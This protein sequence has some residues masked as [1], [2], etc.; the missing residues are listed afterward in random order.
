[1]LNLIP[2]E[3][4]LSYNYAKQNVI[5]RKW[6]IIFVFAWM[7]AFLI[8]SYGIF[9]ISKNKSTEQNQINSLNKEL[10]KEQ[11][12]QTKQTV[13]NITNRLSLTLKV[14]STEVLFSKLI[15]QI[16]SVMPQ[17]AVLTGLNIDQ[18]SGG[19]NLSVAST[20]YQSAT[21]TQVNL[22][23]SQNS[24][25]SKVDIVNISCNG[26]GSLANTTYPCSVQLRALF[27]TNNQFLFINQGNKP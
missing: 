6:I 9:V 24:I 11:L 5:L 4:K 17:G 7:G 25:F 26:Q 18:I 2:K 15:E 27:N 19:I 20:N 3:T 21:Q 22:S 8:G 14:L 1:M 16:G 23:A 13:V 12:V 10:S